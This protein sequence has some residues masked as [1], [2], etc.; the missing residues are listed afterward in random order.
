ME[1]IFVRD[2]EVYGYH[3]VFREE[4]EQGQRFLI[5]AEAEID[6]SLA[7][8]KDDL[9][10][11]VNYGEL[12]LL[13]GDFFQKERYDLLETAAERLSCR[14]LE[15][16]PSIRRLCLEIGKPQAPIDM[17]F[18]NVGVRI[19]KTYHPAAVSLGSNLGDKKGHLNFA[20]EE[21]KKDP[22]IKHLAVSQYFQTAP[23]GYENQEDFLN[24][25]AVFDTYLTPRQL[26][27]RLHQMEA[28]RNR[29]RL[30]RWGPRTLDLD[31][32]FYDNWMMNSSE[33]TIPHTDMHNRMFVLQPMMEI[34][35][36]WVHPWKQKNIKELYEE[37]LHDQ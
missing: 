18:G 13:I 16:F 22:A 5:Q 2:L 9:S 4:K 6:F 30:I 33:L 34:A 25:A 7:A 35:P 21:L 29:E 12:C 32:I 17:K 36:W 11:T 26:L 1:Q 10:E 19:E 3:G 14:I 37:L 28:A 31:I 15:R 27:D 23:Y 8:C 24:A 20:V